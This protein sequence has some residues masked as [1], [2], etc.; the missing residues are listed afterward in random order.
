MSVIANQVALVELRKALDVLNVPH[1]KLPKVTD[2]NGAEVTDPKDKRLALVAEYIQNAGDVI[3][4]L[5]KAQASI[6]MGVQM[7]L[8]MQFPQSFAG[9]VSALTGGNVPP[10]MLPPGEEE[11]EQEPERQMGFAQVV[12]DMQRAKAEAEA[13]AKKQ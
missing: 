11:V 10:G 12:K 2:K 1:D 13:A 7:A 3:N 4:L 8:R 5:D 6:E 9:A